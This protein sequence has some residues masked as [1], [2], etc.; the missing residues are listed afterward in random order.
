MRMKIALA[1]LAF[2]ATALMAGTALADIK[3]GIIGPMTGPNAVGGAQMKNGAEQAVADINAA[4]GING[5]KVVLVVGDDASDPKQGVSVANQ[6][7]GDGVQ[8]VIGHFNSGVTIPT[9][10]VFAE[11]GILQVTP[12]ATNPKVTERGL[13]NIFRTCGRDDQ[14]GALWASWALEHFKDKKIAVI[15]DKTPY[16]QGLADVAKAK[17][18]E[19]GTTEALYE[20]VN[21]GEKDFSA[22]VSKVKAAGADLVM[23]G[24][25]HTEGGLLV[26]QMR[27]AGVS[28]PMMGGDGIN[29]SE[30]PAIGGEGVAGTL[31]SFGPDPRENPGAAEVVAK[32]RAANFEPE[33][34]TLYTYAAAQVIAAAAKGAGSLDSAKMAEYL[35]SGATI[36]TVLG[37]ISYDEKGDRKDVDFVMY[38]WDKTAD[39]KIDFAK[40]K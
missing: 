16:G 4:G 28:V 2:A 34:Y 9:S 29:T 13:W 35:H 33:A 22:L 10:E 15:H 14:Q 12:A 32:F 8:Y 26:R 37:P 25:M 31:M 5:E 11:N 19:A 24:G 38:Q 17:L 1:S 3:L 30:F 20:G 39:G 23:W 27:D 36:D 21:V 40:A 7:V 18:N 6:F